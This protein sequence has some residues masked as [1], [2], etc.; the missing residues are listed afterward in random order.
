MIPC[1]NYGLSTPFEQTLCRQRS[2]R[3]LLNRIIRSRTATCNNANLYFCHRYI[4][5][6]L[7]YIA[8][9]LPSSSHWALVSS[10]GQTVSTNL[11]RWTAVGLT[12][13]VE[14]VTL[15]V[16]L[17]EVESLL[18]LARRPELGVVKGEDVTLA[19][20]APGVQLEALAR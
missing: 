20:R 7:A 19:A 13:G 3:V 1:S 11:A 14:L 16:L 18:A 2:K 6:K 12:L 5:C 10:P 17:V 8:G 4:L 15:S 9:C